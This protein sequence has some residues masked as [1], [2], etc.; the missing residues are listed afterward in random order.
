MLELSSDIDPGLDDLFR[1]WCDH[2]HAEVIALPGVLRARRYL[3][4]DRRPGPARYL[5]IYDLASVSVLDTPAF[6]NHGRTGTPMPDVL[7][8]SLVYQRTVATLVGRAGD[9]SGTEVL[10]RAAGVRDEATSLAARLVV[11]LS[12]AGPVTG[13]RVFRVHDGPDD[14]LLVLLDCTD[15][16]DDLGTVMATGPWQEAVVYRRVFDRSAT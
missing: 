16:A 6:L 12:G 1:A 7:G 3:R 11:P 13:A 9:I 4:A 10:V 8:P 2:H 15:D 5:T 14:R